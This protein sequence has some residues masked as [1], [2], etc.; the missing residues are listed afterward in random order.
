MSGSRLR[1]PRGVD[2]RPRRPH[3]DVAGQRGRIGGGRK[4]RGRTVR[5]AIGRAAVVVQE[6]TDAVQFVPLWWILFQDEG[7]WIHFR[8]CR[9]VTRCCVIPRNKNKN[10]FW[11]ILR[12]Y[13]MVYTM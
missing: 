11:T 4:V 9:V 10:L 13:H 1:H 5:V 8:F 6:Q 2:P 12:K 7:G 3:Q